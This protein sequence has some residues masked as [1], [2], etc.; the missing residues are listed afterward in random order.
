V[1]KV[2]LKSHSDE[3]LSDE[4]LLKSNDDEGINVDFP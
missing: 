4:C 2:T 1:G 3:A